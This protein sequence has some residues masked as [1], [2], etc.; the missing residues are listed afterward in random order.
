[1]A[2]YTEYYNLKKPALNDAVNIN[3]INGNS[4]IIDNALHEIDTAVDANTIKINDYYNIN[5]VVASVTADGVKTLSVL[6]DELYAQL[7]DV[8][9]NRFVF[10]YAGVY[11]TNRIGFKNSFHSM[12]L[13]TSNNLE[14]YYLRL[15]ESG[16]KYG[17]ETIN[18]LT[19]V[20]SGSDQSNNVPTQGKV[21]RIIKA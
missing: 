18:I 10:D 8:S 19:H 17:H 12:Y 21:Y 2:T 14:L 15:Q 16:S 13:G 1:M 6:F 3:D 5:D 9:G 4:D 7:S 11:M 20:V